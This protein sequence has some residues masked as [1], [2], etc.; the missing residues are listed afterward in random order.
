MRAAVVTGA[1]SGIGREFALQLA[2]EPGIQEFWLFGRSEKKLNQVQEELTSV[3]RRFH[4]EKKKFL[5]RTFPVDFSRA[6]WE[7]KL[8][9]LLK[10]NRPEISWLVLAA[11][12]GSIGN[13]EQDTGENLAGMVRVNCEALTSFCHAC[14]PFLAGK[15]RVVLMA[16]SAGFMPQPGFAVYSATKSYV[17]SFGRALGRELHRTGKTKKSGTF[18]KTPGTDRTRPG[19]SEGKIV[20][21]VCP[22]PVA[23]PFFD[24][25]E[26]GQKIRWYKKLCMAKPQ[27]VAAQAISD[28]KKGKSLSVYG[29]SMKLWRVITKIV[30]E[31][32][33][34]MFF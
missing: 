20:T 22:G 13:V 24:R 27:S 23:T 17:L 3:F 9:I 14:L 19:K 21:C 33:L 15:S 16:S 18:C 5:C 28:A 12:Y 10:E 11:G 4:G 1:S 26:A 31:D 32:F 7:E 2:M 29:F 34:M 30:P 25:A 6:G 8:R